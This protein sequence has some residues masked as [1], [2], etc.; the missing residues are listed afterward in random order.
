M[1][2]IIFWIVLSLLVGYYSNKLGRS[3]IGYFV[4]S[5]FISPLIVF[6][7]LLTIGKKKSML[8]IK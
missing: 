1:E 2:F 8:L 7:L 3:F 4:L 6:I 5:V